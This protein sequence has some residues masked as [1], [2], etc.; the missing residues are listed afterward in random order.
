MAKPE[1][2]LTILIPCLDEAATVGTCVEKAIGY[3]R[4]AEIDGEVLVADNGS[5]DRSAT[6]ARRPARGRSRRREGLRDA[7]RRDRGGPPAAT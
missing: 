5:S 3:L 4:D 2:E 7:A 6:I 1:L